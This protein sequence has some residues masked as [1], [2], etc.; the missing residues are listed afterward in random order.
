MI[1]LQSGHASDIGRLR[2]VNQDS[3]LVSDAVFAVADGM[4]GHAGGEIASRLAVAC[5]RR[6]ASGFAPDDVRDAVR[7]ANAAIL[8]AGAG[9]ADRPGMGTTVAG[10]GLALV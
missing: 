8:A 7:Q 3:V 9:H 10:I 4:G 6:L 2:A 1:T 5:L